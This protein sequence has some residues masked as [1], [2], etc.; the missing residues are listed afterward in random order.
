M[1]MINKQLVDSSKVLVFLLNRFDSFV[2]RWTD[3]TLDSHDRKSNKQNRFFT[4]VSHRR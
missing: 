1:R 3:I 2:K 4:V